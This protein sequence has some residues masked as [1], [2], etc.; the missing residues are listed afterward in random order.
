MSVMLALPACL[1]SILFQSPDRNQVE[2]PCLFSCGQ[3]SVPTRDHSDMLLSLPPCHGDQRRE[4]SLIIMASTG[5]TSQRRST[6]LK[7]YAHHTIIHQC[8]YSRI[9]IPGVFHSH[10]WCVCI[11]IPGVFSFPYLVCFIPI[12]GTLHSHAGETDVIVQSVLPVRV[13]HEN[14]SLYV[15]HGNGRGVCLQAC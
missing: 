6:L 7:A 4:D 9:S 8:T 15:T 3:T 2:S 1:G 12:P 10:T 13:S 11:P 14:L 5:M